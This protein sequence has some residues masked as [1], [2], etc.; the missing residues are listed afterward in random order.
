MLLAVS[1]DHLVGYRRAG[2]RVQGSHVIIALDCG[3]CEASQNE[4]VQHRPFRISTVTDTGSTGGGPIVS[5]VS[6]WVMSITTAL[7]TAFG[8]ILP[9]DAQA[10]RR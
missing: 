3:A 1:F 8:T 9:L 10:A 5:A 7:T 6:G 2:V 4:T